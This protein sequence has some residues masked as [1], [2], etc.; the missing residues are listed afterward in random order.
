MAKCS[1]EIILYLLNK[2]NETCQQNELWE[3]LNLLGDAPKN[4]QLPSCLVL[5]F[6]VADTL[7]GF[8]IQHVRYCF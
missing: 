4:N 2:V 1:G 7:I 6:N 8:L 5:F 3:L